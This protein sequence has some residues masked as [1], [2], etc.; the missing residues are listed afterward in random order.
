[1]TAADSRKRTVVYLFRSATEVLWA[2]EVA[3]EGGIPVEVVPSPVEAKDL[4]GLALEAPRPYATALE[5]VLKE[6]GL[7]VRPHG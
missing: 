1:M 7:P 3:R 4:C 2:E 6:E 5:G